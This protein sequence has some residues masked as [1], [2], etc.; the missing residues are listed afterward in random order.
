MEDPKINYLS[1]K[2]SEPGL[3]IECIRNVYGDSYPIEEFYDEGLIAAQITKGL[4]HSEVAVNDAGEAIGNI[5]THLE[6]LGDYTADGSVTMVDSRYRGCGILGELGIRSTEVYR[7]LGLCG[8][9]IY[10][11]A[12]H[13]IVQRQ[14]AEGGAVEVGI[15]PAYFS[16]DI[17]T[18]GFSH[19]QYRLAS[20]MMY[21][22]LSP[23]PARVVYLPKVYKDILSTCYQEINGRRYFPAVD[24]QVAMP[25]KTLYSLEEKTR[26]GYQRLRIDRLGCDYSFLLD[27]LV[28]RSAFLE[29]SY[30]DIPLNNPH[31]DN[32]VNQAREQGFFFG[33]LLVERC[34]SDLLRLQK[35]QPDLVDPAGLSIASERGRQLLDFMLKDMP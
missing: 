33:G 29:L 3:L 20:V 12:W 5:C 18:E 10:A 16:R 15:L 17:E 31:I 32:I 28:H 30:L 23:L 9:H 7:K 2:A 25:E 24:G 13:E 26:N 6:Q 14:A 8:I 1:L 27:Q 22:P 4:L 11:L 21:L 35:A 34:G 19:Q